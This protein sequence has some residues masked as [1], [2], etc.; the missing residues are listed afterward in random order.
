M[1][2]TVSAVVL[3]EAFKLTI[4]TR[5][6]AEPAAN[7]VVIAPRAIGICGSDLHLY[8]EGKIGDS[9]V[10]APVVL[11]HEAAGQVVAIGRHVERFRV[12]DRVIVEP[13][14]ACGVCGFCVQGR[15]NLCTNV[16]FLGVPPSDGLLTNLVRVPERWVYSLPA[17]LSDAEGAMIEPF[18]VGL[19]AVQEAGVGPGQSV[20]ILGAGPIGL[21]VLQAARVRG[22]TTILSIDLAER[23]LEAAK[24]LG[25]T[26]TI[27]PRQEDPVEAV[28]RLTGGAGADIV[29][30][31]VGA[32]PTIR[33]TLDLVARGGIVTL[34]GIASDATVPLNVNAIVR[35]GVQVRSSFRYAHQHPIALELAASGRVDLRS[36]ITHRFPF[37]EAIDAFRYVDTHKAEVVKG[38][39][40]L[41]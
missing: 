3:H 15:Y 21:M 30:E 28:R 16:R 9:V 33:Q 22:A 7:E 36:P 11:G 35:R 10:R 19:Q 12:G 5:E 13:G 27:N 34:V 17:N 23:A 40:E 2:S 31:A 39:I 37:A 14:I 32:T 25:A 38:L 1:S 4:E 24:A 26:A 41:A 29:I 18:A 8:R 20:A 6:V